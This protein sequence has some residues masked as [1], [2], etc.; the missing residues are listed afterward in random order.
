[1]ILGKLCQET[2]RLESITRIIQPLIVKGSLQHE[3]EG[4]A[5][6]S[7]QVRKG[8]LFVAIPGHQ[9]DG[10]D[11]IDEAV[12]RGAVAIVSERELPL[13]RDIA[14]LLVDDA[15]LAL[16]EIS[17][18]FYQHPS[19]RIEL[20]GITGTNGKTTVSFMIR[21]ILE[22]AGRTS[23][24]IG[25]VR[26]EIGQRIIPSSRT[27]PE[28]P[29]IHFMLDQMLRS[30]CR[31]AVMEVSSHALE[32]KRVYG[33]DFD[34]GVFTNLT[35]DHLDYHKNMED[36]FHA[37]SL[38]FRGL[39]HMSKAASAVINLD[40]PWGMRLAGIGGLGADLIL[41][42]LHPGAAVRAEELELQ[43]LGSVFRLISPWGEAEISLP[44]P[45]RYNVSNALAAIAACGARGIAPHVIAEAL[46][47]MPPVPGRLQQVCGTRGVRVFIDYA[48][49]DD[50]LANVLSTVREITTGKLWVVFGCGGNR[51]AT[52][53]PVMGAV[54]SAYA[55]HVVLTND[56]PRKEDP[57]TIL[58]E[59]EAGLPAGTSY[60]IL[61]DREEAIA[62]AIAHAKEGDVVV[63]AGKGHETVQEFSHTVVPFDD[64][65]VARKYLR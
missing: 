6:D 42:G 19:E 3:I 18:A 10:A 24:L 14:H 27:T 57:A 63:V 4:I 7:R 34:V 44:L 40:D 2:M 38:L 49:T 41:Y 9:Q 55:D 8:H 47:S 29:D 58:A 28:A 39:G 54:A 16:A 5:Y 11:F 17:S 59:I 61:P 43:P 20:I 30:G 12:R 32:Q 1:M 31:S 53:R 35:R 60:D 52:K 25:T 48:H 51:D 65:E 37:K 22:H 26:Y 46:E 33:V 50:A 23:G 56:N 64:V 36:Y 13:R 45:G 15:R 62:F 21:H